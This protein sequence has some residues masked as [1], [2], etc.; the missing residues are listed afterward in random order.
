VVAY[1]YR[2]YLSTNMGATWVLQR[3]DIR[4]TSF[5]VTG[6]AA[7]ITNKYVVRTS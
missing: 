5:A 6:L 4:D 7:G 2:V 3:D 1:T